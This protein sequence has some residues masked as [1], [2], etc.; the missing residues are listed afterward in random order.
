MTIYYI[1]DE[2]LAFEVSQTPSY[3]YLR[4]CFVQP[5]TYSC[6][7]RFHFVYYVTVQKNA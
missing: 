2:Q 1:F 3:L 6:L 7:I 4:I 5:A